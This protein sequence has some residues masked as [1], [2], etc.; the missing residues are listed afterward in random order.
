MELAGVAV[1]WLHA[2]GAVSLVGAFACLV[3]IVRP[4][5]RSAG[6]TGHERRPEL[7]ARL[8]GL[9]GWA[10]LLTLGAGLLD[11]WRQVGV[12]TGTGLRESL[13]GGRIL[14]VLLDTRY[15]TVWLAR[16]GLLVLLA[17]LLRLA[18]DEGQDGEGDWLALRLQALALSAASLVLGALAGH[19]SAV[20]GA[21]VSVGLDGLHLLASGVWAGGLVPLVLCL[22]WASRLA[23]PGAAAVSAERFSRLGLAAVATLAITG[24][25]AAWKQVGSVPAL[26]GTAYGRWLLV[27]LFLVGALVPLAARNLLVWRRRLAA[28]GPAAPAA[29]EA[30]RRHVLGEALLALAILAAVAV[31]GLTTPGRHDEIAWPL[32]FRFD[33][34]A[35][36]TLPGVQPRV[37]IGSQV[38]T[39]GLVLLLLALVI[40]PRRWRLAA[41]GG[42]LALAL[43]A[44]VALH[45]LAVDA[46]AATYLRPAVPYAAASIVQG[47]SFYR[48]HCQSCHGAGGDGTGP[49]AAALPRRP[50]DLTAKHASDHTAGDLFWWISQGIPGSGMPGFSEQLTPDER[51]DVIN[52]VRALGAAERTR[53]LGPVASSTAAAVAPD[54][55]F[56]TGVG[57]GRALREWRGRG[58]VLLVFFTLPGSADRLVELNGLTL[59]M[60]LRG[61]EILG[62]P[63][64]DARNVYRALGGRAVFFPLAVD[65]AAEAAS[66]YAMFRRDMTPEG[67]R[68]EPT[69]PAHMELLVDRQGYIRARWIPRDLGRDTDGWADLARLLAEADRLAREAPAAPVA[70]E[71]VH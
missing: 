5:A 15:G 41:L 18:R 4:A 34:E 25:F 66:A 16:I 37:A 9:A 57:E 44:T 65:G 24:A 3:L 14:S 33:W 19:S 48:T 32:S 1:R 36:K 49:A 10:L 12:A 35:T 30:L 67:L 43:G 26:L 29:A 38:A 61:G 42:G 7:D 58:V 23:A 47:R 53:A 56:T 64:G 51:W 22:A 21:V 55:T 50:A 27:K 70:S 31:L 63:Q 40:R 6:S 46:N 17:A 11:L 20:E 2:V 13:D 60:R 54:F 52:F 71:H 39:L 59:A 8:L 28:G 68:P 69:P 62:V 45:P